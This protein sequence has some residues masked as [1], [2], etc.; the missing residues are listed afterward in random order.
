M[1]EKQ[2]L[3]KQVKILVK[4]RKICFAMAG[5]LVLFLIVFLG[6]Y[7]FIH[8]TTD[9]AIRTQSSK[10]S[11]LDWSVGQIE[12]QNL[13]TNIDPIRQYLEEMEEKNKKDYNISVYFEYLHTG[14]NIVINK[15]MQ[16]WPASLTKLPLAIVV[17]KKVQDGV[18]NL[19]DELVL[20]QEDLDYKSGDLYTSNSIGTRFTVEQLLQKLL[21]DSD[22]T[23]Y[24]I[25][26]RNVTENDYRQ[27]ISET[28]LGQLFSSEGKISPKEYSRIL[29]ILF[30]STFLDPQK[31]QEILELLSRST[32]KE[33]LNLGLPEGVKFAHKYGENLDYGVFSDFGIVYVQ[34]RPYIISVAVEAKDKDRKENIEEASKLMSEIS[35]YVYDYIK[36]Y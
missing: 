18:W 13:I 4:Q 12:R 31:S 36:N 14:A 10:Y 2:N 6:W 16:I 21:I 34:N 26:Y 22:N 11:M 9:K 3:E 5:L 25:L 30:Y 7:F 28:G 29:R 20:L 15:D 1:S 19:N 32:F 8:S 35:K 33:F 17:M 27:L 24:K 23:A